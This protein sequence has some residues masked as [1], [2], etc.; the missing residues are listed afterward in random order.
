[1]RRHTI[2]ATNIVG[3]PEPELGQPSEFGKNAQQIVATPQH[4]RIEP[5]AESISGRSL[6]R[7]RGGDYCAQGGTAPA[8]IVWTMVAR[9]EN[10]CHHEQTILPAAAPSRLHALYVGGDA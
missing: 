5:L 2:N 9:G 10:T 3:I 6:I 8:L 7:V 4:G 1:M